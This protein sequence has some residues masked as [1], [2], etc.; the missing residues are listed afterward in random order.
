[1]LV[2]IIEGSLLKIVFGIFFI[3]VLLRMTFFI[4]SILKNRHPIKE[5]GGNIFTIF[6]RFFIPFHR[7]VPKRP[8]YASLRYIFHI[9]LFVVPIWLAGHISLWEESRFEWSWSSIPDELADWMTLVFLALA[10][11]FIIRH[12]TV[13]AVR[14]NTS[15]SDYVIIVIA[16]LPFATGYLLAHGTL[17]NIPFFA[18]NIWT[19]H[20]LSG[21]I[22]IIAAAFLFCRTRMNVLKCTGC[23]SCVSSCPTSTLESEDSGNQRLFHYS[24]YQCI[25]CG[26][27]VNTCPEDAAELRHEI[28][29]KR[30]VQIFT[31]QEIRSVE[32]ESCKRCGTLFVPEPLMGKI[33]KTF[34]HEY[35]EFCPNCRKLS[36]GDYFKQQ[37]PWH[38][39]RKQSA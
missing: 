4:S 37:S 3:A 13:K 20:I 18:D 17:D 21:E 5:S 38:R 9:C 26:S 23:G 16:A 29:L 35:L 27:C 30:F 8:L 36:I 2:S 33:Q 12:F 7:A 22:M 10:I 39:T 1:M 19:M 15:V 14:V 24:H 25:C 31:K 32:M 11:F 6:A 34:T 28:G